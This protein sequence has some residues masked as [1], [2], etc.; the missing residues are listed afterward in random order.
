MTVSFNWN[1]PSKTGWKGEAV[2]QYGSHLELAVRP[3][4]RAIV[5]KYRCY[6]VV[7]TG[8]H[9]VRSRRNEATDVY[10]L[11]N[12]WCKGGTGVRVGG[13]LTHV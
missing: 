12:P 1:K 6:V 5:G 9:T 10:V 13:A 2:Q 3:S 4:P 11:F 8:G 7:N